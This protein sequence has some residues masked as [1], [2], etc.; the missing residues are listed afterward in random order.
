MERHVFSTQTFVPLDGA[1]YLLLVAPAAADRPDLARAM[2]FTARAN[3][4]I[5]YHAGT[6]HFPMTPLGQEGRFAILTWRAGDQDDQEFV[7]LQAAIEV[8]GT[9]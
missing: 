1:P 3:Q 6:W 5:T 7:A 9:P 8:S 2:A 4:A